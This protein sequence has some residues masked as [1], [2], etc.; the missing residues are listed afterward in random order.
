MSCFGFYPRGQADAA[1]IKY[2]DHGKVISEVRPDGTATDG[3]LEIYRSIYR[4]DLGL[5]VKDWRYCGRICNIDVSD[6]N[7]EISGS[8]ADLVDLCIQLT[9]LPPELPIG[10]RPVLYMN[11]RIKEMLRRQVNKSSN[12]NQ[13]WTDQ[14]APGGRSFGG[15][16]LMS[17][18]NG[19]PLGR[20]DQI[21]NT[22]A[23]VV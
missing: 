1:G 3:R 9:E 13:Y 7:P 19:V 2:D 12:L 8:S 21:I 18:F 4:W 16:R 10:A 6:L 15:E 5:T 14:A 22:E 23:Q 11:R 17:F 20:C